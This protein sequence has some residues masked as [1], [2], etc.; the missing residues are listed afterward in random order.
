MS[1][2]A[3]QITSLTIAY[4][5]VYSGPDQR[6]HQSSAS[7]AFVWGIPVNSPRKGPV[8]WK[9]F[10]FDDIIM[11]TSPQWKKHLS[12]RDYC[13]KGAS[14]IIVM[15][16]GNSTILHMYGDLNIEAEWHMYASIS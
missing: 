6:K 10:P 14:D 5:T 16:S 8:M 3:S 12:Q 4:S 15:H 11:I 1:T 2:M 7:Q 9:M 13:H